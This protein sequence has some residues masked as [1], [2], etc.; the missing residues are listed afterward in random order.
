MWTWSKVAHARP[1]TALGQQIGRVAHRL[2]AARDQQLRLAEGDVLGGGGDRVG[3]RQADLVDRQRRD[4]HRDAGTRR[5]LPRGD[6]ALPGLEHVAHDHVLDRVGR[7]ARPLQRGGDGDAAQ[8]H[9]GQRGECPAEA[10][11]RGACPG[12]D[13]GPVPLGH[14]TLQPSVANP[15]PALSPRRRLP[16][17]TAGG[18]RPSGALG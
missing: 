13:H 11:D 17:S 4:G 6:L 5:R 16:E 8:L 2:H 1:E 7:D 10:P 3:A 9:G 12:A 15:N 14:A 18:S